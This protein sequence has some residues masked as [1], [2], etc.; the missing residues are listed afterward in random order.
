MFRANRQSTES[1]ANFS[2]PQLD[3]LIVHVNSMIRL[4]RLNFVMI[5]LLYTFLSTVDDLRYYL[6]HYPVQLFLPILP[7]FFSV[8]LKV[9]LKKID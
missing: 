2:D 3:F 8:R 7:L 5:F 4:V 1:L 9:K 6:F